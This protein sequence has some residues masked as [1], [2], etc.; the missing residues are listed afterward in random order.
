MSTPSLPLTDR[1]DLA[2]RLRTAF[3]DADFTADGLLERLGAPAYA[4]LARAETVPALRATRGGTPLD[5][6]VR[7]FL[8]Q[9]PVTP[10][11][12][13]AAL[14]GGL[15]DDA[16]EGG[17][18]RREAAGGAGD[19]AI[20][21]VIDVRPYGGPDGQDWFIASDLGC[22]VGGAGGIGSTAEGVV[23][24]V[25]G[26][27]TTLAG[28]T[29]RGPVGEAL[30]LG[31]G[32][33]I[34]ALHASV[35]ATRVTATD[36]NPRALSFTALTLALSDAPEAELLEGSLFEPVDGNRYDLIVSNPPFVIS[37]GARLTY[38]DGGMSGDDLCRTLVQQAGDRL[39]EGGYA[40]FLANWQHVDG[41]EWS[42]RL[43]SWVPEGCDA[44]IVQ[45]EVQD[46]T[47]YA[48]LW[49]RDSGD[50]RTDPE[51]YAARYEAW[52]DEFEARNTKA[53]GF[54]WIT[55]RRSGAAEP[56]VVVEEWPHPVEQ[57]LGETVRAHFARQDYLRTHDDAALLAGHF[58]LAPEVVQEQI[59][60]PG[61][62]D[63]EHVVLRQ[64]RGMRRATQVDTVGAGF[65]GVCDGSLSAGRILDAIAQ[66]IGEDPVRL[67]DQTPA[68]IRLLVEQGFLEPVEEGTRTQ[69]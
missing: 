11:E 39:N 17:W 37:P 35:D 50:H 53:V 25:G 19:E 57:P 54:G 12:A 51:T 15:L 33:G 9:R 68:Q 49:L 61:A 14:P 43:R 7:L 69:A 48:E 47:Q 13:G 1:S 44:W 10:A 2:P 64:H 4:A 46:I 65:A 38:R 5:T 36:L 59:G 30:D 63:P 16:V 52:L 56:S 41:E 67:R 42:D 40:H 60:L 62:E 66:L 22:A 31:T 8:L 34:Q 6:L 3:L 45:R 28:L 26:A 23:L 32:S 20:R 58:T 24:G 21:A 18:L 29:V 55:L 27:S